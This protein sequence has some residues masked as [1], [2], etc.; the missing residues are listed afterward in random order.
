MSKQSAALLPA[1][2]SAAIPKLSGETV[3]WVSV[4]P[5][6]PTRDAER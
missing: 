2:V 3:H 1:H 4:S 6:V 5:A